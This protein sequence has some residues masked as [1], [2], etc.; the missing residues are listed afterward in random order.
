M[1]EVIFEA[2]DFEYVSNTDQSND[3][4]VKTDSFF[5]A[6]FKRFFAIKSAVAGLIVVVIILLLAIF[7]PVFSKYGYDEIITKE[8]VV[9]DEEITASGGDAGDSSM[10]EKTVT[11]D[12]ISP[13][14]SYNSTEKSEFNGSTFLFGTDDLG[15]DLW[16]RIWRGTRVSLLIAFV[17]VIIDLIVGIPYGLISGFK[18]GVV[19]SV[20]QRIIEIM[21]SIPGLVLIA[22]FAIFIPKGIG[23][24]IFVIAITEWMGI[25]RIVRASTLKLKKMEYVMASKTLGSSTLK[26]IFKTILPNTIGP[27]VTQVLFTIPAAIFTEAF[28]S[29]IGVGIVLPDCSL[30]SLLENGFEN[31]SIFPYQIIPAVVILALLMISYNA[32]GDG[33]KRAF[34]PEIDD[35]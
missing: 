15:R 14:I 31:I 16:T 19:D 4:L 33:F 9:T 12:G 32:I 29:F 5:K 13:T 30:G 23:L 35:I 2:D 27:I 8:N 25:S 18:G 6:V 1:S 7:A 21:S 34:S 17:T 10:V 22:V 28:L 3:T 11:A 24:V 26:I 20:M